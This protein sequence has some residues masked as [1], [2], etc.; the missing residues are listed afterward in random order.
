MDLR[1]TVVGGIGFIGRRLVERLV[2]RG[3]PVRIVSRHAEKEGASAARIEY[4]TGSIEDLSALGR[5]VDGAS[6][7]VNLVG[8]T[9]AKSEQEFYSLHRDVP[10]RLARARS[11]RREHAQRSAGDFERPRRR[12]GHLAGRRLIEESREPASLVWPLS[13]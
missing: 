12:L 6:A 2:A 3:A 7:I 5:A 13:T 4:V 9:A 10:G 11:K 1:V 8:T